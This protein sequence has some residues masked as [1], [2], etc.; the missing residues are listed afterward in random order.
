[1]TLEEAKMSACARSITYKCSVHVRGSIRAV[2]DDEGSV[3]GAEIDP[4]GFHPDDWYDP[5][6]LMT[7][8][9]GLFKLN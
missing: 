5:S 4:N 7:Y 9:E 8:T 2:T 1:M 6:V 3:I